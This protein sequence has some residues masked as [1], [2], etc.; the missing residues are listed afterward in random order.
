MDRGRRRG[1]RALSDLDD[2]LRSPVRSPSR[3]RCV[4]ARVVGGGQVRRDGRHA[5]V[6]GG[7]LGGV[8]VLAQRAPSLDA[9]LRRNARRRARRGR[10][11]R[12]GDGSNLV[13]C[14][15]DKLRLNPLLSFQS[16]SPD[17][18]LGLLAPPEELRERRVLMHYMKLP[19]GFR[20]SYTDDGESTLVATRDKAAAL[21][22]E[23][24]TRLPAAGL[25]A[26]QHVDVDPP[27]VRGLAL[28]RS[29]RGRRA[30]PSSPPTTRRAA[31]RSSRTSV[32]ISVSR[33]TRARR[34]EGSLHR[35]REGPSRAGRGAHPGYP[36]AA[37]RRTRAAGWSSR[38]G[39]RRAAP[40]SRLPRAG[41]CRR[42]RCSSSLATASRRSSSTS[43]RPG[44][45]AASTPWG[46]PRAPT[47]TACGSSRFASV[48]QDPAFLRTPCS[49]RP[50]VPQE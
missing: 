29:A 13:P 8:E 3:S 48:R 45:G 44:L 9:A 10:E 49:S 26:P 23:A 42:T 6:L 16:R 47:G 27:R 30:S 25:L 20:A 36:S 1:R 33:R 17:R 2:V 37:T 34:R 19:N 31:P 11:R 21:D 14:G 5:L 32:R 22:I 7:A 15:K 46:M 35:A 28:L 39:R 38:T 40:R 41:A 4:G 50:R 43:P 18:H 24:L 12:S